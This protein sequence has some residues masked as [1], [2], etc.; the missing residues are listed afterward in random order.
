MKILIVDDLHPVFFEQLHP[1][2]EVTYEPTI[3]ADNAI[4]M[5][6]DYEGIVVRSKIHFK[7]EVLNGLKHLKWIA[8]AGAGMD[9]IDEKTAKD[10][11]ITL[12]N[13]PEGNAKAVAE[14]TLGMTLMWLNRLHIANCEV[15]SNMWL[16]EKNRGIELNARTVGIIG[17]GFNGSETANLFSA[18]GAKVLVY[19]KYKSAFGNS[20]ILE[21]THKKI[22]QHCD[23]ISFHIPLNAETN[24]M[25]NEKWLEQCQQKPL[26]I[27]VARGGIIQLKALLNALEQETIAGACLDVLENEQI[28]ALT[29]TQAE[30]FKR[31]KS[32]EN[33]IL[34]PHVAGWT[35]ESYSKISHVLANKLNNYILN[36]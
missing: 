9:N 7:R 21:T 15:K 18:L 22:V 30:T 5:A 4:A 3:T 13:A 29:A 25:V 20:N 23:I 8:R 36:K 17:Y 26:I 2:F 24:S 6:K 11:G 1:Q 33:V 34:T 19:D 32:L 28:N 10:L 27:N 35:K 12:F 14:H 16:R 31:L